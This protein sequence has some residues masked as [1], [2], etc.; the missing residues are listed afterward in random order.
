MSPANYISSRLLEEVCAI[1]VNRDPRFEAGFHKLMDY[2]DEY[3]EFIGNR[4]SDVLLPRGN[5]RFAAISSAD[6]IYRDILEFMN[7]YH[8]P[9]TLRTLFVATYY[10]MYVHR[11]NPVIAGHI[12]RR[13]ELVSAKSRA[14]GDLIEERRQA[15]C[16]LF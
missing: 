7:D 5:N 3:T 12:T 16:V 11:D 14:W 2:L 8:S 15:M 13:F 9:V 1:P 10:M 6:R 4:L